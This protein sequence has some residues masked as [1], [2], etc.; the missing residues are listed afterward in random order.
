ML[1][2]AS[3]RFWLRWK[4]TLPKG[5]R[6]SHQCDKLFIASK[7]CALVTVVHNTSKESREFVAI[8]DHTNS[9]YL[10]LVEACT[11]GKN[12][13][14]AYCIHYRLELSQRVCKVITLLRSTSLQRGD[15]E[16]V[17]GWCHS[18]WF[19]LLCRFKSEIL[20]P[21]LGIAAWA[22]VLIRSLLL[23]DLPWKQRWMESSDCL[24]VAS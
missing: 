10:W 13:G 4:V 24:M 21:L 8:G 19:L 9:L 11:V 17:L 3:C 1:G 22:S 12:S 7:A 5:E 23:I 2:L 6:K 20:L 15:G 18:P 14:Y 16:L